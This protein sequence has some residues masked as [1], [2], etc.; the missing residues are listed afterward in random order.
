[1]TASGG[2][3]LFCELVWLFTSEIL[4][5]SRTLLDIRY[6]FTVNECSNTIVTLNV[7]SQP[8]AQ[9]VQSYKYKYLHPNRACAWEAAWRWPSLRARPSGEASLG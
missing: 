9:V 2:K 3:A 4:A 6:L 8:S 5:I 1:M 7:S